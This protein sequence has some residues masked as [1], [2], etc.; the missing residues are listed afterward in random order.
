MKTIIFI[1]L[2]IGAFFTVIS[3]LFLSKKQSNFNESIMIYFGITP[4]IWPIIL[5]YFI[6]TFLYKLIYKI[7]M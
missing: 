2:I 4:F 1:Y 3:W 5:T 7:F 6:Y